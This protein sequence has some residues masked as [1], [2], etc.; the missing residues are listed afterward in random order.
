MRIFA[1][2]KKIKASEQVEY[3]FLLLLPPGRKYCYYS[4]TLFGLFAVILPYRNNNN[5][6]IWSSRAL[7]IINLCQLLE[8]Q[9]KPQFMIV[10]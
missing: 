10:L 3:S 6:S 5:K 2:R 9:T 1:F 8:G 7:Y 4:L